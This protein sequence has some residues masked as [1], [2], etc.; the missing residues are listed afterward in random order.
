MRHRKGKRKKQRGP[1]RTATCGCERCMRDGK[2][3]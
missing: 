3:S 2:H 1:T